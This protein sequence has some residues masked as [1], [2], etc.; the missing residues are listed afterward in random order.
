MLKQDENL[1]PRD[2]YLNELAEANRMIGES[3]TDSLIEMKKIEAWDW[4]WPNALG[5]GAFTLL[6]I[7]IGETGNW[8]KKRLGETIPSPSL[9]GLYQGYAQILVCCA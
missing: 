8:D 3:L 9:Q 2:I 4:K 6:S 5:S 1:K 7:D